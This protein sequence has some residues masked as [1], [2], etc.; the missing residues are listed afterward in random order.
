MLK[1]LLQAEEQC[2]QI[3]TWI[4]GMKSIQNGKHVAKNQ[5]LIFPLDIFNMM[6]QSKNYN[7]VL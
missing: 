5:R 7:T 4:L 6:I 3:E 1:E 2:Y